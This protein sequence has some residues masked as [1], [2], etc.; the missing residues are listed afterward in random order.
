MLKTVLFQAIQCCIST[1]FSSNWPIDRTLS[2]ANTLGQSGPGSD[3]NKGVLHIPQSFS[4]TGTTLSDCL[5]SYPRHSL[6]ESY[7]SA[8]KQSV[9]STAPANWARRLKGFIRFPREWV[10]KWTFECNWSL[11]FITLMPQ[12]I[13]PW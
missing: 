11:N 7:P 8:E 10:Q 13:K 4:I 12:S 6:G 5:V 3:A 2:C 1:L 9:Y